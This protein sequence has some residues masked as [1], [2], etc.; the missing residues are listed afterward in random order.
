MKL[1]L[2]TNATVVDDAIRFV[3]Y[4]TNNTKEHRGEGKGDNPK[5]NVDAYIIENNGIDLQR[6]E[7]ESKY[8]SEGTKA[9]QT[10][11]QIR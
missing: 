7:E 8:R 6:P 4:N 5:A 11:R 10:F 1:D 3:T 2:L 9:N